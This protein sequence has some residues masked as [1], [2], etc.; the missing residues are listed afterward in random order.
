MCLNINCLKKGNVLIVRLAGEIDHHS[1][2][3]IRI[4]IDN[5]I[6]KSGVKNI[7]FDLQR[8]EFMDSS[9][10]GVFVGRYNNIRRLGGKAAI[11][12]CSDRI[13]RILKLSGI[14]NAMPLC[15]SI[16]TAVKNF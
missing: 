11:L 1:A 15:K 12:C 10:I 9:G 13:R 14:H 7:I 5:E 8:V 6:V 3:I 4:R 16:E 2:D